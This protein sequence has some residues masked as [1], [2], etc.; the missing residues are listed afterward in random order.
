IEVDWRCAYRTAS[1]TMIGVTCSA[2]PHVE[3]SSAFMFVGV[4][5]APLD[6]PELFV[7]P[8]L[9]IHSAPLN[10]QIRSVWPRSHWIGPRDGAFKSKAKESVAKV[11]SP[12]AKFSMSFVT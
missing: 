1:P 3:C 10:P 6:C 4:M 5:A 2:V 12:R 7:E 11:W 9:M 8:E